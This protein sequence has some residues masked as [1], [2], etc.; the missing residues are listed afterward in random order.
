MWQS[1]V[2]IKDYSGLSKIAFIASIYA[3]AH[4]LCRS[5]LLVPLHMYETSCETPPILAIAIIAVSAKIGRKDRDKERFACL[6][7]Y[8][9][10][11]KAKG[12][13]EALKL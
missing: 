10:V 12:P 1:R 5:R 11:V 8:L 13:R 6:E 4:C 2:E 9:S 3:L 7:V